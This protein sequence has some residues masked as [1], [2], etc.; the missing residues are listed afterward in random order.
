MYSI[1]DIN[2]LTVVKHNRIID[3][4]YSMGVCE[5]RI[6]LTCI[7]K[8]DSSKEL[9]VNHIFTVSVDDIVD[10]VDV[11]KNSAYRH[12]KNTCDSLF[13]N[14]IHIE[15]PGLQDIAKTR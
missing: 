11:D 7:A 3:A 6:L 1:M 13:T 10:L 2:N 14:I 5:Q 15:L 8:I 12:L 9:P 4:E